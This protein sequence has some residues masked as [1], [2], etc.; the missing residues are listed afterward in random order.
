MVAA[1]SLALALAQAA[2][3]GKETVK[4]APTAHIATVGKDI[5]KFLASD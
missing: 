2:L 1:D 5:V 4:D 3:Y